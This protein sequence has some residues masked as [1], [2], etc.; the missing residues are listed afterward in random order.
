VVNEK[1]L[2]PVLIEQ[3]QENVSN[4]VGYTG[5]LLFSDYW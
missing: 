3:L 2:F 5:T 4:S 1:N